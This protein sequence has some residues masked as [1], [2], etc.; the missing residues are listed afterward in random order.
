[1]TSL[2]AR[3]SDVAGI[4]GSTTSNVFDVLNAV[5]SV[6]THNPAERGPDRT[7]RLLLR[8][9][10]LAPRSG[11]RPESPRERYRRNASALERRSEVRCVGSVMGHALGIGAS[12]DSLAASL[13]LEQARQGVIRSLRQF[14]ALWPLATLA[15]TALLALL[16]DVV[17]RQTTLD[18][19]SLSI[20]AGFGAGIAIFVQRTITERRQYTINLLIA[21]STNEML[22]PADRWMA[23][24]IARGRK[25]EA[26]LLSATEAGHLVSLLDYYEFICL[27]FL[28][29]TLDR[30]V[31]LA[32]RF[33]AMRLAFSCA[34]NY[35]TQRREATGWP[36]LYANI[37]KVI[38]SH[39]RF[40]AGRN[41]LEND[42]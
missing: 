41:T 20:I 29:E 2:S 14:S 33:N 5:T 8:P 6:P 42:E 31:F 13:R 34:R 7:A 11:R 24:R 4:A 17:Q 25:I 12:M 39:S 23:E 30:R 3:S 27:L 19:T 40:H 22:A 9:L 28:E 16:I 1:M 10:G 21:F 32:I 18:S 38:D 35:I 36:G 26:D 15:L 37:E